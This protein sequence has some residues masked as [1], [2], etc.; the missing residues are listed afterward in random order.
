MK[1]LA[2]TEQSLPFDPT[3]YLHTFPKFLAAAL[4]Y[5]GYGDEA[6]DCVAASGFA[7]RIWVAADLCPSAMSIWDFGLMRLGT[8]QSGYSCEYV[9]RLWGEDAIEEERRLAALDVV[10]RSVDRGIPAV[11][12]D[13]GVPEWGL[14]IGY[15]DETETLATFT[16][17]GKESTMPYAE[18]GKRDIPILALL[19]VT[20]KTDRSDEQITRDAM[21]S[22]VAHMKGFEWCDNAKGLEAYPAFL[23]ALEKYLGDQSFSTEYY[24]GTYASLRYYAWKFFEKR[25]YSEL[26]SLYQSIYTSWKRAYDA[27]K[28]GAKLSENRTA[29]LGEIGKAYEKEKA[30]VA[31]LETIV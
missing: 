28:A 13:I 11:A 1:K 24:L 8:E 30:A 27:N 31:L 5:A 7:F 26:A 15:D 6:D 12:W 9:S 19:A 23:A 18:L 22:A 17:E 3:G 10:R 29:I 2:F 20:G 16:C 21:R 25:G 14:L 4:R